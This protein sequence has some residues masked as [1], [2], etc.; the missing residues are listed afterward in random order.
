MLLQ[1]AAPDIPMAA[2]FVSLN[3]L[4]GGCDAVG[5]N[6]EIHRESSRIPTPSA[7]A[8]HV[9]LISAVNPYRALEKPSSCVDIVVGHSDRQ[10]WLLRKTSTA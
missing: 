1:V 3:N 7:S 10:A 4:R 5:I 9:Y 8:V 2:D 6:Y